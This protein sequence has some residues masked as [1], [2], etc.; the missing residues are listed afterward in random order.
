MIGAQPDCTVDSVPGKPLVFAKV[1]CKDWYLGAFH[2]LVLFPGR[3]Y[4]L[5]LSK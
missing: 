1:N 4:S 2:I 3:F 5:V